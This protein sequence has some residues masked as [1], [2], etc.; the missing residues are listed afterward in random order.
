MRSS[1]R[2]GFRSVVAYP[3]LV[4]ASKGNAGEGMVTT[5]VRAPCRRPATPHLRL[6]RAQSGWCSRTRFPGL[7]FNP[8]RVRPETAG[9]LLTVCLCVPDVSGRTCCMQPNPRR[10]AG[11]C[12]VSSNQHLRRRRLP[13]R[14]GRRAGSMHAALCSGDHCS[15][16]PARPSR[17]TRRLPHSVHPCFSP[18]R[19]SSPARAVQTGRGMSNYPRRHA[20]S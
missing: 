18:S 20:H 15:H 13:R 3:L 6:G 10:H 9:A 7:A 12:L 14:S 1:R 17:K 2:L 19:P 16:E 11:A 4:D 5:S 8:P